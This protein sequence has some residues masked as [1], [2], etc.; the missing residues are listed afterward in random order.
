L[1]G[2]LQSE[3]IEAAERGQ[4][5]ASEGSVRHVEVFQLGGVRTPIIGR[6]RPLP[7]QRR[8]D[9]LY[10]LNCEE[11]LIFSE[12]DELAQKYGLEKIK[13]IGDSYMAV[14]GLPEPSDN[15]CEAVA[16]FAIDMLDA[17]AKHT[18]WN[19]EKIRLRIGINTGPVV[20]GVIGRHKFIYDLWG[21][22]VN[23]ASRMESYGL[24]NA[25]Q[26]TQAVKDRLHGKYQFEQRGPVFIKGKGNMTTYILMNRVAEVSR[27]RRAVPPETL[28]G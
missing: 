22:A 27:P 28:E 9:H 4:I 16:A 10:T 19:G 17:V 18:S 6:P 23:T 5:R 25:I 2:Y 24:E 15:H 1:P 8:A 21:D 13:T 26:V 3:L 12:F 7:R 11:P 14:G 20:A